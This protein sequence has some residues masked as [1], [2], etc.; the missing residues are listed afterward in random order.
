MDEKGFLISFLQKVKRVF[1]K[2]AFKSGRVRHIAQ[3]SNR[4]W[5]TVI[6]TTYAD[7]TSLSPG[8]IY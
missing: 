3:D 5:L 2:Q 4:E 7:G 1:T 6:A 8:F